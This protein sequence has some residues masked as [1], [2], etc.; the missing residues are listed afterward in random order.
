MTDPLPL[1][2]P[3]DPAEIPLPYP[4]FPYAP[5][6]LRYAPPKPRVWPVFVAFIIVIVVSLIIGGVAMLLATLILDGT[7]ILSDAVALRHS[8]EEAQRIPAVLFPVALTT[9]LTLL[10]AALVAARLSP[11]PL[12]ARLRLTPSSLSFVGYAIAV[13]GALAVS[14]ACNS[15]INLMGFT[16]SGT[17]KLLDDV[18]RHLSRRDMALAL[19]CVALAAGVAEETYFRGYSQTRLVERWGPAWGIIITSV[20]FGILHMDPVHSSFA[21]LFGLYLGFVAHR[22]GS[23]RPTIACHIVN[24]GIAVVLP[25]LNVDFGGRNWDWGSLAVSLIVVLL[26][27]LYLQRSAREQ[28]EPVTAVVSG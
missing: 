17:L 19:F 8:L 18:M 2:P 14:Q 3:F 7:G 24:N 11:V 20:L 15:L 4:V 21:F 9:S 28:V 6:D 13:L 12:R 26:V 27:I 5:P 1:P 25:G 22:V 16:N 10:G 23:I